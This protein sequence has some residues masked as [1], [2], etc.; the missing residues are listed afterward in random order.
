MCVTSQNKA[1]IILKILLYKCNSTNIT[2]AFMQ[3]QN[4][5]KCMPHWPKID[6]CLIARNTL[7]QWLC[8]R[9]L[10]A[11]NAW[12]EIPHFACQCKKTCCP[13]EE[14]CLIM[15]ISLCIPEEKKKMLPLVFGIEFQLNHVNLQG[16]LW[17]LNEGLFEYPFIQNYSFSRGWN[18][19]YSIFSILALKAF[20]SIFGVLA[21][22][23]ENWVC[24]SEE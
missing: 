9:W 24:R 18:A 8:K 13:R 7:K 1:I 6:K 19:F 2:T 10:Y 12:F 17:S 15:D 21:L 16:S 11:N 4:S 3:N 5:L 14:W 23:P 20:Y 22:K